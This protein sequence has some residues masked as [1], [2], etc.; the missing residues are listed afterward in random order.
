MCRCIWQSPLGGLFL[1]SIVSAPGGRAIFV[2]VGGGIEGPGHR[3]VHC[4]VGLVGIGE[5]V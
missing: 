5:N 1:G 2:C 4:G 3:G